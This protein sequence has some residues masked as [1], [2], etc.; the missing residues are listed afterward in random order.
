MTE[1]SWGENAGTPAVVHARTDCAAQPVGGHALGNAALRSEILV[2]KPAVTAIEED[3]RNS[4]PSRAAGLRNCLRDAPTAARLVNVDHVSASSSFR[5]SSI[6][7]LG[8]RRRDTGNVLDPRRAARSS[9]HEGAPDGAPAPRSASATL[10]SR[11]ARAVRVTVLVPLDVDDS[12]S[13]A[14]VMDS[15]ASLTRIHVR[16]SATVRRFDAKGR[17]V[18]AACH[19]A[20]IWTPRI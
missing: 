18:E 17:A 5:R 14:S 11:H 2:S 13:H 3:F 8:E 15:S 20:R 16:G 7:T 6:Q 1:G 19:L 9:Q 10:V 4:Y 12:S